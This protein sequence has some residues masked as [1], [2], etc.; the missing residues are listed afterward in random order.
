MIVVRFPFFFSFFR[1]SAPFLLFCSFFA[2]TFTFLSLLPPS[3][4]SISL[5][6]SL[7]SSTA[8][9]PRP[10][11]TAVK[12]FA[13]YQNFLPKNNIKQGHLHDPFMPV[14]EMRQKLDAIKGHLVWMPL[15][16]LRDAAMAEKGL[17]INAYTESIY[18]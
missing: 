4:S 11:L 16:F 5:P 7:S 3:Y 9:T 10:S 8:D 14:E 1:D 15:Q 17:T 13:D 12:T 18:T 2:S 6:P